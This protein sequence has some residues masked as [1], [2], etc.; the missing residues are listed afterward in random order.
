MEFRW[1]RR[2]AGECACFGRFSGKWSDVLEILQSNVSILSLV[3]DG[4]NRLS[5]ESK[6]FSKAYV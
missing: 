4:L 2:L 5:Y 6:S 3:S 1:L